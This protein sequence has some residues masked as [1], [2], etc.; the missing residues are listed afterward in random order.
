[1]SERVNL[2]RCTGCRLLHDTKARAELCETTDH[3]KIELHESR[4][5]IKDAYGTVLY[6]QGW[7]IIHSNVGDVMFYGRIQEPA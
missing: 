1:M 3:M 7:Q 2:F 6:S 4:A 5:D